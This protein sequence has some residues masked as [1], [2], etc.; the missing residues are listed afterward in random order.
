MSR[1]EILLDASKMVIT[2][3]SLHY[4]QPK[5]PDIVL[6]ALL[7]M[8]SRLELACLFSIVSAP[9]ARGLSTQF[10]SQ[11]EFVV[12]WKIIVTVVLRCT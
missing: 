6:Y 4:Y 9:V 12:V 3:R 11:Y 10:I 2:A 1:V 8:K 5:N 7:C